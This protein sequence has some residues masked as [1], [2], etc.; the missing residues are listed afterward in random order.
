MKR[1]LASAPY[2]NVKWARFTIALARRMRDAKKLIEIM[3]RKSKSGRVSGGPGLKAMAAYTKLFCEAILNAWEGALMDG[4]GLPHVADSLRELLLNVGFLQ[5][6]GNAAQ[7]S[8]GPSLRRM[9][10]L[11]LQYLTFLFPGSSR[12]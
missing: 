9:T 10:R 8:R 2:K 3:Y 5:P 12:V 7:C 11:V 6:G 1:R 4:V